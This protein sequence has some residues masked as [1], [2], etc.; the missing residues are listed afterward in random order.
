M[1]ASQ[2][3]EKSRKEAIAHEMASFESARSNPVLQKKLRDSRVSKLR[4]KRTD[5]KNAKV[6]GVR[7]KSQNL[8]EY[9]KHLRMY[10]NLSPTKKASLRAELRTHD[11]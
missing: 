4:L 5:A 9:N 3:Y 7:L 2:E 6:A 8:A 1:F 11:V 10:K